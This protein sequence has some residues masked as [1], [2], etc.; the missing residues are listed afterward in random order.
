LSYETH[1]KAIY[2]SRLFNFN[3]LPE[4]KNSDDYYY[5]KYDNIISDE[6]SGN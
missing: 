5:K 2:T 1:L 3:D 6:Y 4:P